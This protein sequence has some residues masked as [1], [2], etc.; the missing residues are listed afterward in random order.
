V[1]R[2]SE[3]EIDVDIEAL[4]ARWLAGDSSAF[5][6]EGRES[7]PGEHLLKLKCSFALARRKGE[8]RLVLPGHDMGIAGKP[9]SSLLKALASAH[10]WRERIIAGEIYSREQLAT[11][12]KVTRSYAGRILRLAALSP[13]IVDGIVRDR[14]VVRSLKQLITG[15]P[16]EWKNQQSWL[17]LA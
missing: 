6:A 9:N 2:G 12:A 13:D 1:L 3:T 5:C 16:L 8:L 10:H 11:E 14:L 15:L 17:R 4:A 7:H